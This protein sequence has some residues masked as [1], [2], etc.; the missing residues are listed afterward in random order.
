MRGKSAG[1]LTT[2]TTQLTTT[3]HK[4]TTTYAPLFP[5]PPL[6]RQAKSRFSPRNHVQNL[7][8]KIYAGLFEKFRIPS[9]WK[10]FSPAFS[11]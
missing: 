6:K 11:T 4:N 7:F 5:K 10:S 2:F 8:L 9:T 1:K 3:H